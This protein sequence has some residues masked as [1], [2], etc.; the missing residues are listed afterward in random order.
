MSTTINCP[1]CAYENASTAQLC[2]KC[3]VWL[4]NVVDETMFGTASVQL[5]SAINEIVKSQSIQS[6]LRPGEIA[7]QLVEADKI[8]KINY[9]KP[10]ILGRGEK[11]RSFDNAFVDL[12]DY[13]AYAQGVSRD[14]ALIQFVDG[15]YC[16]E[17]LVSS[18]GVSVNDHELDPK[19]LYS[20]ENG[21]QI[22]LGR[23]AIIFYYG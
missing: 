9:E 21:D 18:N 19:A 12:T 4:N 22:F 8:I 23:F 5:R 1:N 17:D 3:G 15:E 14:H 2:V 10:T 11:A 13:E 20:L 16:I 6:Q 7:F